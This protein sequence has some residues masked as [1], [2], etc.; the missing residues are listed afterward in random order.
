[1]S[2]PECTFALWK[3]MTVS[4]RLNAPIAKNLGK[5]PFMLIAPGAGLSRIAYTSYAEQFASDGYIVATLDVGNGGYLVFDGKLVAPVTDATGNVDF[6]EQAQDMAAHLSSIV[7][8]FRGSQGSSAPTLVR[9]I[10]AAIDPQRIAAAGHSLG[11]AAALNACAKDPR[12]K[13]CIDLD[14]IPERPV[15]EQGIQ[16]KCTYAEKQF[17]R[18]QRCGLGEIAP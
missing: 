18:L 13:A 15:A 11:G 14:G 3:H 5:R 9:D 6:G 16:N 10:A 8:D 12:I 7:D 17:P 2:L 1:M 4:A